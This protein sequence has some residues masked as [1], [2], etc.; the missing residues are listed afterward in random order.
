MECIQLFTLWYLPTIART[1]TLHV[2][3]I[4]C[5]CCSKHSRNT[6]REFAAHC[7]VYIA[8]KIWCCK[9]LHHA[10]QLTYIFQPQLLGQ[11]GRVGIYHVY[12]QLY[13]MFTDDFKP[14]HDVCTVCSDIAWG[15]QSLITLQCSVKSFSSTNKNLQCRKYFHNAK[16]IPS[17]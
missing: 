17:L 16:R 12:S 10:I 14:L 4:S 9:P 7:F 1:T 11:E 15:L 8:E 3:I 2:I 5:N 6:S 13:P